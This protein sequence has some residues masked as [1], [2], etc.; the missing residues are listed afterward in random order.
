MHHL[1]KFRQYRLNRSRDMAIFRFF[2]DGGRP[3]SW[4]C[5][6]CVGTTHEGHLV[7][8]ITVQSLVGID[9]VVLIICTFFDFASLA[10][11]RLFAPQNWVFRGK[12]GEGMGRY[13]PPTNSFLLLGVYTSVSNWVKID[14]EMRPWECPQMDTH[15][16]M[17]ARTDA[18]QFY[19]LSHAIC[20]SYG[21]DN[22]VYYQT[23]QLPNM[24]K[25][26]CETTSRPSVIQVITVYLIRN[27]C[28][29]ETFVDDKHWTRTCFWRVMRSQSSISHG[30]S[31]SGILIRTSIFVKKASCCKLLTANSD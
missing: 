15:T 2:Q 16:C 1:A 27:Y 4:I 9:A 23:L 7:V 20:Y 10:W 26:I 5:N 22:E 29:F 24:M 13:S 3:P 19:Y 21:A 17:H 25:S 11:K 12:V 18:K 8:F 14:E 28:L 31:S 30:F 6:A